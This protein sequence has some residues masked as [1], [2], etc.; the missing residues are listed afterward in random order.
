M[1]DGFG[2][3]LEKKIRLMKAFGYMEQFVDF[4]LDGDKGWVLYNWARQSEATVWGTGEVPVSPGY[5]K[6]ERRLRGGKF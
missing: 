1:T 4:G 6:Q 5:I 2:W 3:R